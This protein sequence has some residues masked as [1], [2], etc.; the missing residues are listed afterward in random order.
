MRWFQ[1]VTGQCQNYSQFKQVTR[2]AETRQATRANYR[3]A[4]MVELG[5]DCR[6]LFPD[7]SKEP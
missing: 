6:T 4:R 5:L 3:T 7:S 1:R 2:H